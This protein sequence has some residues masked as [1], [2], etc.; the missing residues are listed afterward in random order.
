[1]SDEQ[2]QSLLAKAQQDPA[3]QE[4]L[5]AAQSHDEIASIAAEQGHSLAKPYLIR[6]EAEAIS[7]LSDED[8]E[9]V[10]GGCFL[11][12]HPLHSQ[13]ICPDCAIAATETVCEA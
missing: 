5:S 13:S 8:L 10:A 9:K 6:K 7:R 4:R 3:L 12:W 11:S 1:M 2:L